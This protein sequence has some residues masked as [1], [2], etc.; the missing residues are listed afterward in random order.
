MARILVVDDESPILDLLDMI[1]RRKGHDVV[2]ANTGVKGLEAVKRD[3]PDVVILDLKMPGMDGLTLLREIRARNVELPVIVLTG[4]RTETAETEARALGV[5]QFL[6][7]EF[8]LHA[9]GAAITRAL[10]QRRRAS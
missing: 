6:Q 5:I 3:H 10:S 4:Y 1:L 8:S 2:L 7:K 9:L